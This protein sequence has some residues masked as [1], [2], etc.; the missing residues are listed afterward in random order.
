MQLLLG[1]KETVNEALELHAIF[2]TARPWKMRA[3]TFCGQPDHF[4][5][6][7]PAK[8]KRKIADA[9]GQNAAAARVCRVG[10]PIGLC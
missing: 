7:A 1:G 9:G 4:Q 3:G 6:T 8:L 5:E 2:L 10:M